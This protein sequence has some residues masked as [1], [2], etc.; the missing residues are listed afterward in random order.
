MHLRPFL[1]SILRALNSSELLPRRHGKGLK[2][3]TNPHNTLIV[4]QPSSSL[5]QKKQKS[6]RKHR[7]EIE[8]PS[9][10]SEIPNEEGVPIT[11]NDPLPSGEDRMRLNELMILYTNL[12]KHVLDLEEAKT[13]QA[14]EIASK[15]VEQGVKVIE[16]EISIVDPVTTVGEVVTTTGIKVT[17]AAVTQQICKDELTLAQTLIEIKEAQIQAKLEEEER[18]ARLKE[19]ETNIALVAEWDNTQ[20]MMNADCE[21]AARLQEEER[22]ER[23]LYESFKN[24]T[25]D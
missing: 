1:Q 19:E 24:D 10:I 3:P 6:R 20:A 7:K 16:K 17:T 4:T 21:L 9:P 25:L 8:V 2:I 22:R 18:L 11:S 12:K 23:P 14:E 5:P 15:K 13:A